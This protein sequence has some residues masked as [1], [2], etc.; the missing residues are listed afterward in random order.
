MGT[1]LQTMRICMFLSSRQYLT[2]P[3][4]YSTMAISL[5]SLLTKAFFNLPSNCRALSSA[6]ARRASE[7]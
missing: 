4:I 5:S 3:Q 2:P 1:V 7:T 6:L